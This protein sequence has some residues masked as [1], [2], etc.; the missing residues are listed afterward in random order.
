MLYGFLGR[1]LPVVITEVDNPAPLV[2]VFL[3]LVGGP[4][5]FLN[6]IP[7]HAINGAEVLEQ[8]L[9]DPVIARKGQVFDAVAVTAQGL[10]APQPLVAGSLV[11]LPHLMAMQLALPAAYPAPKAGIPVDPPT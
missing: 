6:L 7:G 3:P 1:H 4:K 2:K 5:V 11:I 10:K 8:P 9:P